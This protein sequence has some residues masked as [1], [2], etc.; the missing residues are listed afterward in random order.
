MLT[1]PPVPRAYAPPLSPDLV[2]LHVDDDLL[3]LDKPSGLLTVPGKSADLADCLIARAEVRFPGARIVHRLDMDTSGVIVLA[4]NRHAHRHLGLQFERRHVSKHY[5]ARVWGHLVAD[6]G[7]ID[8]PLACDWPNRPRQH[9]DPA[10]GRHART[11]W[12][13]MGR[14]GATT[15]LRLE[16]LTGR[17]HQLRVHMLTL[18]HPILGDPLYAHRAAL[19]AAERLQLHAASLTI[20]HPS[21]GRP[22]HFVSPC[23][24]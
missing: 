2:V 21:G 20:R 8:L 3:V 9:I 18:G 14:D 6:C 22:C 12:R 17:S 10:G 15:R 19:K 11:D 4:R 16:P 7:T 5:E 23:P 24:F 13:V 1:T